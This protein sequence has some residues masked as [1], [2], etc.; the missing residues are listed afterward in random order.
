MDGPIIK[1][2]YET[3]GH[4]KNGVINSTTTIDLPY[5]SIH[6]PSR[7]DPKINKTLL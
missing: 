5:M 6:L 2:H 7:R 3:S 1:K 4:D